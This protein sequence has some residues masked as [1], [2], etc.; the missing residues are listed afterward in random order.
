[1]D[2]RLA[3]F[4]TEV[5]AGLREGS[6]MTASDVAETIDTPGVWDQLRR[7][8]EDVGI[9]ES[10]I[11]ENR[12]YI[13]AWFKDTLQDGLSGLD[14]SSR[15]GLL[16]TTSKSKAQSEDSGRIA[17][18]DVVFRPL[19]KDM[20][21][22]L[23]SVSDSGYGGSTRGNSVSSMKS[24][25]NE[26]EEDL[27]RSNGG[28]TIEKSLQKLVLEHPVS[29]VAERKSSPARKLMKF[30]QKDD[31]IIQAAS[32]GDAKKVARLIRLGMNVNARDRWGWSALSM[33]GYG[34][35]VDIARMLLK[36]GADLDNIDVDGESPEDLVR[37]RGNREM[38]LLFEGVRKAREQNA[39]DMDKQVPRKV[40]I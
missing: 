13:A 23:P 18:T 5:M 22:P 39:I 37:N 2:K 7:E 10:V 30:L 25:V 21:Y 4:M 38:V 35:H 32:D 24:A 16:R 8:L 26:F 12:E 11:E 19:D 40:E 9:S 1:M 6:V 14:E 27:K 15:G 29:V 36:H 34:G 31:A 33:C 20:L 3:K 17:P 28:K